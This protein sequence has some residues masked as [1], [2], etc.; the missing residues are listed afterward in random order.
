MSCFPHLVCQPRETI[1]PV[2]P[3]SAMGWH[4]NNY[5]L[6]VASQND[7]DFDSLNHMGRVALALAASLNFHGTQFG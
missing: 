2:I 1:L 5:R 7:R 6:T 4:K 3:E